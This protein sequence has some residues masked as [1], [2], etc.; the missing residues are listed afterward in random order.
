[1][2]EPDRIIRGAVIAL[3]LAAA[4]ATPVSAQSMSMG[5]D[6]PGMSMITAVDTADVP[7]LPPMAG[8]AEG[9]QI[10]CINT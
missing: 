4:L 7:P 8:Y 1:M 9:E 5:S 2:V 10:F 3:G 6:D